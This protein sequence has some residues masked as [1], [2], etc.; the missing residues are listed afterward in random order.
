MKGR[1]LILGVL[2]LAILGVFAGCDLFGGISI[3]ER[4]EMFFDDVNH[5]P[6]D[7]YTNFHPDADAYDAVKDYGN[8]LGQV[9][10][11]GQGYTYRDLSV[12]G[13]VATAKVDGGSGLYEYTGEEI[14]FEMKK[15]GPDWF[16]WTVTFKGSTY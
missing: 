2:S 11:S 4:I 16:I 14:R 8:T 12:D 3:E 7:V 1:Y 13:D 15:E 10:P 9:L 6:E 5:H